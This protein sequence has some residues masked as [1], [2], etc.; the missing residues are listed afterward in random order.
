MADSPPL[1]GAIPAAG[2]NSRRRLVL[3][4]KKPKGPKITL[5]VTLWDPPAALETTGSERHGRGPASTRL[6]RLPR[7]P[8]ACSRTPQAVAVVVGA[9]Y[10][11]TLASSV[12]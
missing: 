9:G 7:R 1:A 4:G 11:A 5:S 12:R 8:A 2:T 6:G 10:L 3:L